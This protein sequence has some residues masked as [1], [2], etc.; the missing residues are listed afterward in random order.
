MSGS[1]VYTLGGLPTTDHLYYNPLNLPPYTMRFKFLHDNDDPTTQTWKSGV[2]WTRVSSS[3]NIWDCTYQN[4]DWTQLFEEKF[5]YVSWETWNGDVEILGANINGVTDLGYLFIS[6]QGIKAIGLF[7]T[8][9]VNIFNGMLAACTLSNVDIPLFN[10]VN[11]T[12][13]NGMFS[14][15]SVTEVPLFNTSNVRYMSAMFS[16]CSLIESVPLFD[17][18]NVLNMSAMFQGCTKLK[19]IPLFNTSSVTHMGNMCNGCLNVESGAL[20]LYKQAST[21]TNPPLYHYETF[22]NCGRDTVTGSAELAQ[23]PSDWK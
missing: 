18:A 7:D 15:S 3:P 21:Q 14:G 4:N 13:M 11:A 17:T 8:Y 19:S 1:N 2:T 20:A 22:R 9:T 10:T 16:S 23:I 5:N 6:C 12:H